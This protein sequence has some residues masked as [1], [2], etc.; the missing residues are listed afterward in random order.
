MI[1][2]TIQETFEAV[3]TPADLALWLR[4]W[5]AQGVE[6]WDDDVLK[7]AD[8]IERVST[9]NAAAMREALEKLVKAVKDYFGWEDAPAVHDI[10]GPDAY[11]CEAVSYAL[12][13]LAAPARNCDRFQTVEEALDAFIR[14]KEIKE[15]DVDNMNLRD[16][17][18]WLFATA[19][20]GAQR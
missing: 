1:G 4:K 7:L 18:D 15:E 10:D 14:E 5:A 13:A 8:A 20:E 16:F 2:K 17:F 19:K 6:L 3:R 12:A 9:G 11:F